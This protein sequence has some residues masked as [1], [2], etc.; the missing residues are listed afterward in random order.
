M[1]TTR[2]SSNVMSITHPNQLGKWP[3]PCC[4]YY[5]MTLPPGGTFEVCPVCDWEDDDVQF[6]D[7]AYAGGANAESL[8]EA[9]EAFEKLVAR[10]LIR[11][12]SCREPT[13]DEG[14]RFDWRSHDGLGKRS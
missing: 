9:R 12:S 10:G 11:T 8:N 6:R 7:P 1:T 13:A 2:D 4:G 5:T 3:C 14:P